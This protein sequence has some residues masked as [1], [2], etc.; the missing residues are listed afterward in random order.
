MLGRHADLDTVGAGLERL[1]DEL[2]LCRAGDLLRT[3]LRRA[4]EHEGDR[5]GWRARKAL[6]QRRSPHAQGRAERRALAHHD[7][8]VAVLADKLEA[9]RRAEDLVRRVEATRVERLAD[10]LRRDLVDQEVVGDPRHHPAV[11]V[12]TF[13]IGERR[14]EDVLVRV[15]AARARHSPALGEQGV[16]TSERFVVPGEKGEDRE[17]GREPQARHHE[18]EQEA[19]VTALVAEVRAADAR[20]DVG[21]EVVELE[22]IDAEGPQLVGG[23]LLGVCD[24]EERPRVTKGGDRAWIAEVV[25]PLEGVG[26]EA[27]AGMTREPERH[28][29]VLAAHREE[30]A[31]RIAR[32]SHAARVG[33]VA[34]GLVTFAQP[35]R[36][37]EVHLVHVRRVI[38]EHRGVDAQRAEGGAEVR[39]AGG[40]RELALDPAFAVAGVVGERRVNVDDAPGD[41]PPAALS[42]LEGVG[43]AARPSGGRHA[44]VRP[45]A[46]ARIEPTV[47]LGVEGGVV[48]A[49]S[50]IAAR[51]QSKAR[52]HPHPHGAQLTSSPHPRGCA[53][54]RDVASAAVV[55][56]T[57]RRPRCRA[58][59][60]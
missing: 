38:S 16:P 59:W 30:R 20:V 13:S 11:A 44:S 39:E 47:H 23:F 34:D 22:A 43:Q 4:V 3:S 58:S 19:E 54:R 35:E 31:V 24:P 45:R 8:G 9:N 37:T 12:A 2:G 1:V 51:P 21:V 46:G 15:A 60:A 28:Q 42:K 52:D 57:T 55:A 25:E 53:L 33:R 49:R 7:D 27:F 10:R 48:R 5:G 29:A 41:A 36:A 18:L 6:G 26:G 50:A 17:I 32:A 40:V 56:R 14:T